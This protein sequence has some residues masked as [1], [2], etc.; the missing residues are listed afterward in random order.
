VRMKSSV[1]DV[2][3]TYATAR[4]GTAPVNMTTVGPAN[5]RA[6]AISFEV[7]CILAHFLN[8]FVT[9][10]LVKNDLKINPYR[11]GEYSISA[12]L[13]F[14]GIQLVC[15]VTDFSAIASAFAANF[16]VMWF[17]LF[18]DMRT[19]NVY[20]DTQ[21]NKDKKWEKW[22]S[23][24][25]AFMIGSVV[26]VGPWIGVWIAAFKSREVNPDMDLSLVFAIVGTLQSL[27]FSFATW[28]ALYISQV[29]GYGMTFWA[30]EFG[31]N[32][33]SL[34]S[35]VTLAVLIYEAVA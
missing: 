4:P 3:M 9:P 1:V 5:P 14:T 24:W 23:K 35:K 11:W 31:Y 27:F 32:V 33:L 8:M 21:R 20:L 12:S 15:G 19:Q 13:M 17:G 34:V 2:T 29:W 28:E 30:R 18:S 16:A 6:I 22:L 26:A 7:I 25:L 10:E